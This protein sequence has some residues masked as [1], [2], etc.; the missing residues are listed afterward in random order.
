MLERGEGDLRD[1]LMTGVAREAL[2][3]TGGLIGILR[4]GT[5]QGHV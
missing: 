3:V 4:N 2:C 1:V 5:S